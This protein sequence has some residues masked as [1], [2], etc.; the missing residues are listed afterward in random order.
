MIQLHNRI[1]D[2]TQ[3]KTYV[4]AVKKSV[5]VSELLFLLSTIVSS[6]WWVAPLGYANIAFYVS[7]QPLVCFAFDSDA[8]LASADSSDVWQVFYEEKH[9]ETHT[10][11]N[12][13][14]GYIKIRENRAK[15]FTEMI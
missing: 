11:N 3:R 15:V 9:E 10:I 5:F 8:L 4:N 13:Q 7:F 1:D 12:T 14:S 2:I 6:F